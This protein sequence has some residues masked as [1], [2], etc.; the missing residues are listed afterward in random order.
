V[1][2]TVLEVSPDRETREVFDRVLVAV[3]A[4]AAGQG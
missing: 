1:D 4:A 2:T 3:Q